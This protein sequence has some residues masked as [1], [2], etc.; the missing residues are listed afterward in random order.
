MET[1]F[2]EATHGH[3]MGNWGKF[4]LARFSAQE[5]AMP[6]KV[7]DI[8]GQFIAGFI[9]LIAGRGWSSTTILALDLQT[10]EGTLLNPGGLASA[11]LR[12][13]RIWVCPLFEPFLEWVYQQDLT[14]LQALPGEVALP[15][16]PGAFRGYRREGLDALKEELLQLP[17]E[18]F[19][20]LFGDVFQTRC[21]HCGTTKLP[22]K[23][24]K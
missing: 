23:E 9:S 16:A 10:G 14:D 3:E 20:K 22:C 15:N 17:D 1:K 18:Q 5:W 8:S 6:S 24:H 7:D 13:H 21:K 11:D 19:V 4:M 12:K 2:I